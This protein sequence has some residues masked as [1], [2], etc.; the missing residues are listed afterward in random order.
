MERCPWADIEMIGIRRDR[1]ELIRKLH[2]H[3]W[4]KDGVLFLTERPPLNIPRLS[5]V[6]TIT[7]SRSVSLCMR[8]S[9]Q[10]GLSGDKHEQHKLSI[11]NLDRTI[12]C[13]E[14][15]LSKSASSPWLH[16]LV[17]VDNG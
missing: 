1:N 8:Q 11:Q 13:V 12:H 9:I 15:L 7:R 17:V 14:D 16:R 4:G 6:H 3:Y 5:F 10:N 2:S